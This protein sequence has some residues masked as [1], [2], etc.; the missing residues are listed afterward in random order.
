MKTKKIGVVSIV[1]ITVFACLLLCSPASAYYNFDGWPVENRKSGTVNGTVFIGSEPWESTTSLTG[2]FDVP[3]GTVK[4]ARLYTGVWGGT[5]AYTGWVNVSF[6]GYYTRNGLGPIHLEGVNDNNPNVWCTGCGKYWMWYNVTD[7]VE[8]GSTNTATT[9]KINGTIDGRVYGI[10]LLA[11]LENE[12]ASQV[13]Y[14]IN[15]GSDALHYTYGSH[16]E[17][18][19]GT[20][21]FDGSVG[22]VDNLTSAALTM[23]HLTG[24][25]PACS[26]CLKFNGYELDTSMV[27]SNDFELNTWDV[28]DY[29]ETSGNNA[30]FCRGDDGYVNVVNAILVL[31]A[32]FAPDLKVSGIKDPVLADHNHDYT[33]GVVANHTYT[34]NATIKN[35]GNR[36]A[37]ES[38]A[39]LHANGVLIDTQP[40]SSLAPGEPAEIQFTWMPTSPG[41]YV[42]NVTA[43]A[44]DQIDE[45]GIES[46]ETN[47]VS[48]KDMEVLAEGDPDLAMTSNDLMFMPTYNWHAADNRT[49]FVVNVSNVGTGDANNFNV[50]VLVDTGSGFVLHE[51]K[52]GMTV[53]AKGVKAISFNPYDAAYGNEYDVK[54]VLDADNHVSE[55]NENNNDITRTLNVIQ[56]RIR[57]THHWGDNSTY[58]GVEMFDVVTLVPANTTAWEALKSVANVKPH[59]EK[60][61]GNTFVY[62]IDGLETDNILMTYWYQYMNGRRMSSDEGEGCGVINLRDNE[63]LHCDYQRQVYVYVTSAVSGFT[64]AG[65]V[66][67]YNDLYPEPFAHGFPMPL[68]EDDDGFSRTI[69][70]TTIVYPAESPEYPCIAE[71]I[72]N[73]FI[74]RGVPS[75]RI[76]IAN[77]T[78][79]TTAQKKNNNLLLLGT[80]TANDFIAELNPYH[81]YFGM[82]IYKSGTELFDDSTD[83]TYTH[84]EVVQ[85]F[86]NPYDNGPLGTN[87]SYC[88]EGP[89]ILMASGLDPAC[90][91]EAANLLVNRTDELD[92]FWKVAPERSYSEQLYTGRNYIS[93]PLVPEDNS[94]SSV[95][96]SIAGKYSYVYRQNV[97]TKQFEKYNPVA[98]PFA[99]DFNEM[100]PGRLYDVVAK[101]DCTWPH[102]GTTPANMNILLYT[103]RNYVGWPS[104]NT[105]N[106]TDALTSIAGK[107]SYVY[108]QNLT[109]KQFE[110]YNPSAPPFAND[111]NEME[112][113]RGYD[114]VTTQD[115]MWTAPPDC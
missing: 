106:I 47:N 68:E 72:K 34:I 3:N 64:P 31:N 13:Q 58:N 45:S 1:T 115:C 93:L 28:K 109:T 94:T 49:T 114:I 81:E 14:W 100:D 19:E 91:K 79:V 4:W 67:S 90:A 33:L 85:V 21:G 111:F 84:G 96:S 40:V 23:V 63:T 6:N 53:K 38:R 70:N 61:P 74:A 36:E 25:E 78:S 26:K 15:D 42:L 105:E 60:P 20:T 98:P 62:G 24:Y 37:N 73:K 66:Q 39:T 7:L 101:E 99:N 9:S 89:V 102:S 52:T 103:G 77:D 44:F 83:K 30:W 11:V 107:Y 108:R 46:G 8:P 2:N 17:K 32:P 71:N 113:T 22:G 86:D 87:K 97:T 48:T 104:M 41:T 5:N 12:S 65:T 29:M 35:T 80:Y 75:E 110:K 43:D 69:W 57:D 92:W 16:T 55:S 112:P 95:L 54:V 76:S 88:I 50:Q 51:T 10:V 59:P 56:V 82:V 27:D 18:N